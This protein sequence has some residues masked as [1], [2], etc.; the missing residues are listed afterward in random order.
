MIKTNFRTSTS[1]L[2]NVLNSIPKRS[3]AYFRKGGS[4]LCNPSEIGSRI[5]SLRSAIFGSGRGASAIFGD[6]S[7]RLF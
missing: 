5:T 3:D 2:I 6:R 4:E 7:A 1:R